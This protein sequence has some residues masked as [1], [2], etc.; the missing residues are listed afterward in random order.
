AC[1][2]RSGLPIAVE[3]GYDEV[4]QG[5]EDELVS[6]VVAGERAQHPLDQ[7]P[8]H[9]EPERIG[10]PPRTLESVQ[11]LPL[12]EQH[13]GVMAGPGT[14]IFVNALLG[15]EGCMRI[16]EIRQRLGV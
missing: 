5:G 3:D 4:A 16:D 12:L 2:E 1:V 10:L 13:L 9:G 11:E 8:H 6:A 15:H 7:L 14:R